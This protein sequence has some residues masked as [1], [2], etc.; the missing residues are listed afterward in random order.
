MAFSRKYKAHLEHMN[1]SGRMELL[2]AYQVPHRPLAKV[3]WP[4]QPPESD[5]P[6]GQWFQSHRP[7]A[8]PAQVRHFGVPL[9]IASLDITWNSLTLLYLLTL[10][11]L[12]CDI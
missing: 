4:V 12:T 7:T 8:F 3:Q 1:K 6:A 5:R 2:H 10:G 9:L 11:F